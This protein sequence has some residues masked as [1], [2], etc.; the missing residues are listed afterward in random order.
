MKLSRLT[1]LGFAGLALVLGALAS[2]VALADPFTVSIDRF[3]IVRGGVVSFVD[4]FSDGAP[5]PAAPNFTN[6]TPA[7]YATQGSFGAGAESGGRLTLGGA[8]AIPSANAVGSV[9]LINGATLLT[10]VTPGVSN[11]LR[12]GGAFSV[13]GLFDYIAPIPGSDYRIRLQDLTLDDV[14]ELKVVARPGGSAVLLRQQDFIAGTITDL[15]SVMLP[16]GGFDQIELSLWHQD[17]G[18]QLITASYQIY[19]GGVALGPDVFLNASGSLFHGEDFVRA[20]FRASA[21]VP[22]PGVVAL[23]AIGLLALALALR[24][25]RA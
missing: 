13:H 7:S 8:G 16:G 17:L 23:F 15:E 12:Q 18:S 10:S 20:N 2:P 24:P 21:P 11:G 1:G 14:L 25:R 6:N 22:E 9:G 3:T 4:E 5:P 19:S